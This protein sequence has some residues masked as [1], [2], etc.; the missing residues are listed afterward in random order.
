MF[1]IWLPKDKNTYFSL[2]S[3]KFGFSITKATMRTKA[4]LLNE[5]IYIDY[6]ENNS[7]KVLMDDSIEKSGTAINLDGGTKHASR[8][9][10][11]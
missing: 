11:I 8:V 2:L 6:G 3:G 4:I 9:E 10:K 7:D 1:S 5:S